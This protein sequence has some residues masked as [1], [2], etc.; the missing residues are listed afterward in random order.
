MI[1][2]N[3]TKKIELRSDDFQ[4]ILESIPHWILRWGITIVFIVTLILIIGSL[5][6][7]YPDT[8][9]G[10]VTLTGT[11]PVTEIVAKSS[12]KIQKLYIKDNQIVRTGD[13]LAI[14]ENS[15][16]VEDIL[17]LKKTLEILVLDLDTLNLIPSEHLQLGNLQSSY[18]SFYLIM[19][20]YKR[21]KELAYYLK[22]ISLVKE[23]ILKNK[24][25][26]NNMLKQQKATLE[27]YKISTLQY[28][29]DSVLT[30]RGV[31]SKEEFEKSY[32]QHLQTYLSLEG[33]NGSLENLQ[34][35]LKQMHESLFDTEYEYIE[36]KKNL[37]IQIYSL[38]NQLKTE[39]EAWELN[40]VLSAPINGQITFSKYWIENQ[41]MLAGDI[42]F[43][44][45]P[46][47]HGEIIGKALLPIEGSGKVKIGQKVN[48]RFE[49]YP[50]TQ[51]GIVKGYVKN[52]SLVPSSSNN[53]SNYTIDIMLSDGLKTSYN[54]SLPYLPNMVGKADIITDDISLLERFL[55]PLKKNI[56]EGLN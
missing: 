10:S 40:Y 6:F 13:F 9:S 33:M 27:L 51:Y 41:N 1:G 12:G 23:R 36:K 35:Q 54:R 52:I 24:N 32:N 22:K 4:E 16:K 14:I 5:I 34:I 15:A 56:T 30:G 26:Y 18:S 42:V 28:E 49:N 39:I 11:N 46:S 19:F 21:F 8:I 47:T 7:K 3:D 48:I 37:E 17:K 44:I 31:L 53:K 2:L 43:N 55:L 25:Y 29:R 38:I 50:D 20:E 45:V